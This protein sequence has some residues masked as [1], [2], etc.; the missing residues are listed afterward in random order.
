VSLVRDI[1]DAD[2]ETGFLDV[3]ANALAVIIL[4]TLFILIVSARPPVRGDA[5]PPPPT[6]E[7]TMP[8]RLDEPFPPL[9]QYY[10]VL[11]PG[12]ADLD[13]TGMARAAIKEVPGAPS[14]PEAAGSDTKMDGSPPWRLSFQ[15]PRRPRRD[16]S[17]YTAIVTPDYGRLRAQAAPLDGSDA[18]AH[19]TD[20]LQRRHA[21]DMLVPTFFVLPDGVDVFAPLYFALRGQDIPFRWFPVAEGAPLRFSHKP[22]NAETRALRW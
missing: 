6:G 8:P 10:V 17:E 7:L 11:G 20:V 5:P 14:L 1:A 3:A 4:A 12:L 13:L 18:V 9:S 19:L 15:T 21:D 16:Y 22:E 2:T